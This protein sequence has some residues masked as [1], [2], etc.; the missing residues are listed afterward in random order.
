MNKL[1]NFDLCMLEITV[2]KVYPAEKD[3]LTVERIKKG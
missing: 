2:H 3:L 1:D